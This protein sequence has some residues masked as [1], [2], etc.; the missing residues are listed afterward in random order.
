LC[1][2]SCG[3]IEKER[4]YESTKIIHQ[5]KDYISANLHLDVNLEHCAKQVNLSAGYFSNL[6]KKVSGISF[7]QFVMQQKMEKAKAMLIE[8]FQVQEI[9]EKL[10]YEHR[11][12]L[13][14]VFKK[15]SG[16][17]PSEFKESFLGRSSES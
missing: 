4:S 10:G 8:D 7:Q 6:F 13:T 11:R 16:M 2:E 9:A 5:A 3:W 12:Y 14:D 15:Y 17:T 1:L